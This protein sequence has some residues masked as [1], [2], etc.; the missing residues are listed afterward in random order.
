MTNKKRIS[1]KLRLL[2]LM[3]SLLTLHCGASFQFNIKGTTDINRGG[4]PVKIYLFQLQSDAA[5]KKANADGFWSKADE[6][7]GKDMVDR[8]EETLYPNEKKMIEIKIQ[9]LTRFIGIA[10]DFVQPDGEKWRQIYPVASPYWGKKV[11][12]LVGSDYV[13]LKKCVE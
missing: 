5:F 11:C 9:K 3:L 1:N 2:C 12:V 6:I 8:I 4:N 10:G 13:L 7:L